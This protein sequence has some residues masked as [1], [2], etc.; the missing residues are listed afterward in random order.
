MMQS[1]HDARGAGPHLTDPA[2]LHRRGLLRR[3]G[4]VAS[5]AG[6]GLA[7]GL[8]GGA[9]ARASSGSSLQIGADNQASNGDSTTLTAATTGAALALSNTTVTA[10]PTGNRAGAALRLV[11]AG[12]FPGGG[13]GSLGVSSDGTLY[14]VAAAN[15]A[16]YVYTS[17]TS[18][19]VFPIP[20]QRV[21]DTRSPGR[22]GNI[23]NAAA[24]LNHAGEVKPHA[25][26]TV[27]L[28]DYVN[29]GRAVF[30]NL[31]VV[32]PRAG[33]YAT[34]F[35]YGNGRPGVST[36]NFPDGAILANSFVVAIGHDTVNT[37]L[38]DLISVYCT[39]ATHLLLDI[40]AFST[41]AYSDVNW[42]GL[43]PAHARGAQA[44]ADLA[45]TSTP[46]WRQ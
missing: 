37:A 9:P 16:D 21:F 38:T 31:T 35:P 22:R 1:M 2:T 24:A 42:R 34:V 39:V 15:T 6:A 33:G 18:T 40:T 13:V 3:A 5:A 8:V 44:R 4:T 41:G 30:G 11:P 36:L 45:R 7:A 17:Y 43:G 20:P 29:V 23:L 27:D 12:D 10:G 28:G 14:L 46:R 19:T 32:S 26:L 25:T